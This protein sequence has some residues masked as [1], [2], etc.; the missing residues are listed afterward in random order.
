MR[1]HICLFFLIIILPLTAIYANE[2]I[3]SEILKEWRTLTSKPYLSYGKTP[4]K[5]LKNNVDMTMFLNKVNKNWNKLSSSTQDLLKPVLLRPTDPLYQKINDDNLVINV[6]YNTTYASFDT[7]HFK[8]F[9][10][11]D[12]KDASTESFIKI[13][14]EAFESSYAAGV[15]NKGF[16]PPPDDYANLSERSADD[17]GGDSKYDVYLI[18]LGENFPGTFGWTQP[19]NRPAG[20][21]DYIKY[22]FIVMDNDYATA[23]GQFN[24]TAQF[25][26][27]Q[28]PENFA[29]ITAAHEFFHAI[30]FSYNQNVDEWFLEA[31]A[32]WFEDQVYP[33][34]NDYINRYIKGEFRWFSQPE[35]PLDF[36]TTSNIHKYGSGIWPIFLEKNFSGILKNFFEDAK[37]VTSPN[38]FNILD[39]R[40]RTKSS[41]LS[42]AFAKFTVWNYIT[43][44]NDDGTHYDDGALYDT[45]YIY[46]TTSDYM[47]APATTPSTGKIPGHLGSNYLLFNKSGTSIR[48]MFDGSESSSGNLTWNASVL[49][50]FGT[51]YTDTA[52]TLDA[53]NAGGITINSSFD[54]VILIPGIYETAHLR[55]DLTKFPYRYGFSNDTTAPA[56]VPALTVSDVPADQGFIISLTWSAS[57]NDTTDVESYDIFRSTSSGTGFALVNSVNPNGSVTYT[58]TNI[59]PKNKTNFYYKI[60][61]RDKW[62]NY[63]TTAEIES[64]AIA[65]D[66]LPPG[67]PANVKAIDTPKDEGGSIDVTW[68]KST[69]DGTGANDVKNY[70][71]F[72]ATN[73]AGPFQTA[74]VIDAGN[75]IFHDTTAANYTDYYY[76]VRAE[77][78]HPNY[79]YSDT[80]GPVQAKDDFSP[81]PTNFKAVGVNNQIFLNWKNPTVAD[82]K[83]IFIR[84]KEISH[85]AD[86]ND[87]TGIYEGTDSTLIDNNNIIVGQTYYYTAISLDTTGNYSEPDTGS[88]TQAS[89]TLKAFNYPN[90]T[91]SGNTTIRYQLEN[92]SGIEA[93]LYIFDIAGEL[94][95]KINNV[96][97]DNNNSQPVANVPV[98][99]YYWDGKNGKGRQ[100]SSGVYIFIVE[101]NDNMSKKDR[102]GKIAVIK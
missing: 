12:G 97:A 61:P 80:T 46:N 90:P 63:E 25:D 14:A 64:T 35:I 28:S 92:T 73:L 54:T 88:R 32:V 67:A 58:T 11:S 43:G 87:G 1:K 36:D 41:N 48:I 24:S 95:L 56:I 83:K 10:T 34:I 39:T 7:T 91:Y 85:P 62:F 38:V 23:S 15:T 30:Q 82:L 68:T 13:V 66:N 53:Q 20:G 40:L 74:S 57:P 9:Y 4:P 77:D 17:N 51:T 70:T 72:R 47:S 2:N 99:D 42:S 81:P 44:K 29:R 86:V 27:S 76:Y 19:E 65:I 71:I 49:T 98:Y 31:S 69:D 26:T 89:V 60:R 16:S 78:E 84:R 21:N 5:S 22:S 55:S 102:T 75:I 52:I 79:S 94:V 8:I 3:E 100:V 101:A 45:L 33:N 50:K 96:L 6:A 93:T 18:D 59:V 37:S